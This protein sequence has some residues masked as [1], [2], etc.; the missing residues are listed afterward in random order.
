MTRFTEFRVR[1]LAAIAI[2]LALALVSRAVSRGSTP[3][4]SWWRYGGSSSESDSVVSVPGS[5]DAANRS[6]ST[7]G[8]AATPTPRSG[9]LLIDGGDYTGPDN[10]P[11]PPVTVSPTPAPLFGDDEDNDAVARERGGVSITIPMTPTPAGTSDDGMLA[12]IVNRGG[13]GGG[14]VP[15]TPIPDQKGLPW[16]GGQGR[17]YAMLY[18][19]QPEAR[20][21]VEANV[22]T[23]LAA[24]VREPFIGVLIDGTF[25]KDFAY[26]RELIRR[27]NVD[28]RNLQLAL[29]IANGPAQR[30]YKN[31]PYEVP[32]VRLRPEDFRREIRRSNS[33]AQIQY[34]QMLADARM[35]FEYNLKT[36]P[37]ARNF[38]VVML[39][40]NLERDSFRAMAQIAREQV[41]AVATIVRNPC[42]DC[43]SGNDGEALGYP[44]EEHSVER[45]D[46]LDSNGA[47]TLDGTGFSYPDEVVVQGITSEQV[48]SLANGAYQRGL[49]YFG[50]WREEWQG[51][52]NGQLLKEPK[53]R[54]YVA[55]SA[56]ETDFE[57]T[58]LRTG[59]PFVNSQDGDEA[60]DGAE[61]G[62]FIV[63]DD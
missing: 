8:D 44:I 22:S 10:T 31:P 4:S 52:E 48:V 7:E 32:F 16:V 34:L 37:D 41:E 57:V 54:V 18:A 53:G 27:L 2:G 28:G 49:R 9:G 26:L 51:I 38:A 42:V 19:L 3:G 13:L 6:F 46:L 23:L 15:S 62:R 60:S 47:F 58:V 5:D 25:G 33:A 40:D 20:P 29:Y 36:N 11:T 30:R 14:V 43:Y 61:Q 63:G 39:E 50:L 17:G 59:L 24:R 45:F 21:V 56:E 55:S 35:L 1:L 12:G